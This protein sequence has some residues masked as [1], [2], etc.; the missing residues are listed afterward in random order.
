MRSLEKLSKIL[1]KKKVRVITVESCTG[2]LL[3]SSLNSVP[4]SSGFYEFGIVC[5]SNIAKQNILKIP[6]GLIQKYGAVSQEVADTMNSNIKY[7]FDI[8]NHLIVSITGIAGPTGG[9][10]LKPIGTTYITIF[11]KKK[12]K[13]FRIFTGK[14]RNEIQSKIVEFS[15]REILSILKN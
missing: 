5:Y 1:I 2:G 3:A 6:E 4:G 11:F 15:I 7:L 10:D 14:S 13:Y 8:K 12:Y 9:C